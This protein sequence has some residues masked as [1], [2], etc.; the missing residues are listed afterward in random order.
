[1]SD[2]SSKQYLKFESERTQA[3]TDLVKRIELMNPKKIIDIGCG[4]GNS[5]MALAEHF[6]DADIIGVDSSPNMIS[7]AKLKYPNLKFDL[8]DVS[9]DVDKLEKNVDVVFSNACI[10]WISNHPKLLAD[11]MTLLKPNGILAVQIPVNYEEPIHKII[12]ETAFS[13]EWIDKIETPRERNNLTES[14]YFDV[15]SNISKDFQIWKTT[16]FHRLKSHEDI[17]EWYRGTGL[18]PYLQQLND[19]DKKIFE[20]QI[21]NKVISGYPVQK[22]GEIIF[23]FPRLFFVATK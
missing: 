17:M 1:M 11:L 22:N 5:T 15:L 23:R 16:Y 18:R 8:C 3:A 21:L 19:K 13:K 9:K 12:E 4:P 20:E 6:S 10:Q 14:E 2:W 7:A